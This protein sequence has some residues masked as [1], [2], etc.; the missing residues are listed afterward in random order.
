M[1]DVLYND[2]VKLRDYC[3][4]MLAQARNWQNTMRALEGHTRGLKAKWQ[5]H[6]FYEFEQHARG[7][8]DILEARIAELQK[9]WEQLSEQAARV[10]DFQKINLGR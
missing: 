3:A 6:Q 4:K 2:P 5:D 1:S 8:Y 9:L 10:E 7:Q